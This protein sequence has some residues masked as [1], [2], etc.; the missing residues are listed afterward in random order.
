[1]ILASL[2]ARFALAALTGCLFLKPCGLLSSLTL[3]T[4]FGLAALTGR[5]A[6]PGPASDQLFVRHLFAHRDRRCGEVGEDAVDT[7]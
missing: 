4:A 2:R 1:M 3:R 6:E 5:G 7:D